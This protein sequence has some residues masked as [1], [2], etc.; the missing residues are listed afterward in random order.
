SVVQTYF[1]GAVSRI[2]GMGLDE[3]ERESI[4][5]HNFAFSKKDIP[6][7]MLPT[8]GV[9]Q[10]KRKGEVHLFNPQTI[11][12]LQHSTRT[13]DFSLFK[14]YSKLVNDQEEKA[15]TL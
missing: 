11:H 5:K 15:C 12:Y 10:W 14:K 6:V 1:T 7:D 8:G 2:E 13:N 9:Y 4:A 3:I